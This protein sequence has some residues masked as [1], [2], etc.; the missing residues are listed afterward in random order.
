M[1]SEQINFFAVENS[2]LKNQIENQE[3]IFSEETSFLKQ[4]LY[5]REQEL[6]IKLDDN[7]ENLKAQLIKIQESEKKYSDIAKGII[8][9]NLLRI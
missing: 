8:L 6:K 2:N 9:L 1:P 3:K 7:E 5:L 4:E